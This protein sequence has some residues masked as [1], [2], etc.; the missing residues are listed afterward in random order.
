M[1]SSTFHIYLLLF[2][3]HVIFSTVPTFFTERPRKQLSKLKRYVHVLISKKE[4][5]DERQVTTPQQKAAHA[6]LGALGM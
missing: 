6:F 2:S 3:F 1:Y 5:K 4:K